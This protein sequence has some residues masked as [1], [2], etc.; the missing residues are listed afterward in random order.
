[1][2]IITSDKRTFELTLTVYLGFS[3]SGGIQFP[4]FWKTA[5]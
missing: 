2:S 4:R 1:M 3:K 5:H